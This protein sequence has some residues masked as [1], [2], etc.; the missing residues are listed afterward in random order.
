MGTVARRHKPVLVAVNPDVEIMLGQNV[1]HRLYRFAR[2]QAFANDGKIG[3]H[4]QA[5]VKG[6]DWVLK[7]KIVD[8]HLHAS[9]RAA[10]GD[11]END[12]RT[13]DPSNGGTGPRRQNLVGSD[14]CTVNVRYDQPYFPLLF[15][16]H[17]THLYIQQGCLPILA[18]QNFDLIF[19]RTWKR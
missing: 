11:G 6:G 7:V 15:A 10:A 5:S 17:R 1:D 2:E 16:C 9:W 18:P 14:Q 12:S 4:E 8:Q 19:P 3:P 13:S